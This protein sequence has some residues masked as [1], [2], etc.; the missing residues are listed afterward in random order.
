[1]GEALLTVMGMFYVPGILP[2]PRYP[3]EWLAISLLG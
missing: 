3:G 1:M 2:K